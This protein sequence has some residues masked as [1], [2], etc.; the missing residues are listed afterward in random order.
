MTLIGV[1][2]TKLLS[3]TK[4]TYYVAFYLGGVMTVP[5]FAIAQH[6]YKNDHS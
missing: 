6:L 4:A 2:T 3:F 5:L 1:M